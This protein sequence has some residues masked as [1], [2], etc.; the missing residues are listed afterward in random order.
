MKGKI[1]VVSLAALAALLAALAFAGCCC[2]KG[3]GRPCCTDAKSC[4]CEKCSPCRTDPVAKGHSAHTDPSGPGVGV[5]AE[6][7]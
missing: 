6:K 7:R 1:K 5:K 4:C 3:W 2:R